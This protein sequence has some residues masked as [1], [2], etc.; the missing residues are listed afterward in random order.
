MKT[1]GVI[2]FCGTG[3]GIMTVSTENKIL[4]WVVLVREQHKEETALSFE[5][6]SN[7]MPGI[8]SSC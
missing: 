1:G 5:Y 2:T 8:L 4:Q 7:M 6:N 3:K